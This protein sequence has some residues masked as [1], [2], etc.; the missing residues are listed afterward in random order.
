MLAVAMAV[1]GLWVQAF[2]GRPTLG[3]LQPIAATAAL[4]IVLRSAA[5]TVLGRPVTWKNRAY[6]PS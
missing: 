3:V 5:A 1:F 2:G 6:R 4:W